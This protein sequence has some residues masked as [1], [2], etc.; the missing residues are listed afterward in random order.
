MRT[1]HGFE[2][3][4]DS[5]LVRTDYADDAPWRQAL[6]AA[7]A[8]YGEEGFQASFFAVD[9]PDWAE[10]TEAEIREVAAAG[11][12]REQAI[13]VVDSHATLAP[14]EIPVLGLR[15]G[16]GSFRCPAD[17]VAEPQSNLALGNLGFEEYAG[18]VDHGGVYR[19][20]D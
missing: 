2:P 5:L 12:L 4:I 19:G 13:F 15:D 8:P 6:A 18:A 10:A 20:F 11:N 1:F 9:D 3:E 14:H 16:Q 17:K 7:T